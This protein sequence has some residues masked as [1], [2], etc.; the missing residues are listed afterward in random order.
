ML[1]QVIAAG[2]FRARRGNEF[3]HGVELMITRKDDRLRRDA[4]LAALAIILLLIALLAAA[5]A[6]TDGLTSFLADMF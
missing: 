1:D 4:D 6:Q 2:A 5:I 3:S